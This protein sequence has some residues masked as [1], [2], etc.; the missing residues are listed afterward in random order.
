LTHAERFAVLGSGDGDETTAQ[1]TERELAV[2]RLLGRGL[3]NKEIAAA[4]GITAKT[5][6]HHT[7]HIYRKLGVRGRAE[8]S[9][10]AHRS[11][12]MTEPR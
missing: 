8:A 10:V 2:L 5:A 9:A 3:A 6:M 1:L 7:S 4:L 12:L 11:G